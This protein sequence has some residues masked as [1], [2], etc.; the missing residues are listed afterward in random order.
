MTA[1][2]LAHFLRLECD[3]FW[4]S[5]H[6]PTR[7]YVGNLDREVPPEKEDLARKFKK[8]G[9]IVDVWVSRQPPGFAFVTYD[10]YKDVGCLS[11]C[12]CPANVLNE[13]SHNHVLE[14]Y[15]GHNHQTV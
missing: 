10:T 8:Y 13:T 7:I 14:L 15:Q 12:G 1:G 11:A 9:D 3:Y 6:M 2:I 5:K 4:V